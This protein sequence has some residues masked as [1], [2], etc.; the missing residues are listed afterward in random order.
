[1]EKQINEM[2]LP[3]YEEMK[4]YFISEIQKID[5]KDSVEYLEEVFDSSNA[6]YECVDFN[7]ENVMLNINNDVIGNHNLFTYIGSFD[8]MVCSLLSELN[9]TVEQISGND[10][11]SLLDING[12]FD[13]YHDIA[14]EFWNKYTEETTMDDFK[15]LIMRIKRNH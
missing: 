1:M 2:I 14:E 12:K 13:L 8:G 3:T 6:L 7:I 10:M 15:A 11:M 4:K 5:I 9:P